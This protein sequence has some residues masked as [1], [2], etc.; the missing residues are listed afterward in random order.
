MK[1]LL[2]AEGKVT[3]SCS[4]S[5][6]AYCFHLDSE[7]EA[8]HIDFSYDPKKLLDR[9]RAKEYIYE[10]IRSFSVGDVEKELEGWEAYCPL[11]NLITVSLDDADGFRGCAHR[12]APEQHHFIGREKASHGFLP[13][14]IGRGMWKVTLNLH[15]VLTDA[16]QYRLHIWEGAADNEKVDSL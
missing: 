11:Q 2:L 14:R 6:I 15:A 4:K 8:L 5:H 3:P 16:C 1:T 10:G 7:A 13:G 9:D 12:Q